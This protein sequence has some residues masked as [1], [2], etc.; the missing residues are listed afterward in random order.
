VAEKAENI[1]GRAGI[2]VPGHNSSYMGGI[3]QRILVETGL[4]K[5]CEALSK[6]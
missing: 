2:V 1:C 5:K 6:K 4:G 3:S